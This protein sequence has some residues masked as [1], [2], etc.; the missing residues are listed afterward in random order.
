MKDFEQRVRELPIF[1]CVQVVLSYLQYSTEL[2]NDRL[3]DVF[4]DVYKSAQDIQPQLATCLPSGLDS[5]HPS[6]RS[7]V[8]QLPSPLLMGKGMHHD[9]NTTAMQDRRGGDDM[10]TPQQHLTSGAAGGVL[11]SEILESDLSGSN[12]SADCQAKEK[13]TAF[14]LRH[15]SNY[16]ASDQEADDEEDEVAMEEEHQHAIRHNAKGGGKGKGKGRGRGKIRHN[17]GA[18]PAPVEDTG[19]DMD[20]QGPNPPK[21]SKSKGKEKAHTPRKSSDDHSSEGDHD[22][23]DGNGNGNSD[24]DGNGHSSEK[25]QLFKELRAFVKHVAAKTGLTRDEAVAEAGVFLPLGRR[26]NTWNVF[27]T[28]LA[29]RNGKF[30]EGNVYPVFTLSFPC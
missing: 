29:A 17:R 8:E 3:G 12:Y 21:S 18:S 1:E 7:S 19:M 23:S 14:K 11:D 15:N 28:L 2:V 24:S 5:N 9:S 20:T 22:D 26:P 25:Q 6:P 4:R 10:P 30:E 16:Q 27:R 13:R